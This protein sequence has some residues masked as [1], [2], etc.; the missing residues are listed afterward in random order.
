MAYQIQDDLYVSK[1]IAAPIYLGQPRIAYSLGRRGDTYT[2]LTFPKGTY[3]SIILDVYISSEEDPYA[4][5]Y[6]LQ[7]V[8]ILINTPSNE[9]DLN[10]NPYYGQIY[11]S[12]TT[13]AMGPG[14]LEGPPNYTGTVPLLTSDSVLYSADIIGEDM[15]IK[16][17]NNFEYDGVLTYEFIAR[18]FLSGRG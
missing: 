5:I 4:G 16:I 15:S 18:G 12:I 10:I 9:T 7:T 13:T 8:S 11:T 2:I 14:V 6:A 3:S 17:T 1:T